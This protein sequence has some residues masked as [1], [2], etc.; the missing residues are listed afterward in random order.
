MYSTLI[1]RIQLLAKVACFLTNTTKILYKINLKLYIKLRYFHKTSL[2]VK[3]TLI[4]SKN[5]PKTQIFQLNT[6]KTCVEQNSKLFRPKNFSNRSCFKVFRADG[7]I[8]QCLRALWVRSGAK[9]RRDLLI[10]NDENFD[11]I[12]MGENKNA[13]GLL[14]SYPIWTCL[15]ILK[16]A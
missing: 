10:S 1:P 2:I 15:S 5:V 11:E 16:M 3:I 8:C 13:W 4:C 6:A 7:K 12:Y 14:N 9:F